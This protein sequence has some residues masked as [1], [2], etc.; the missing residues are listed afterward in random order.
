MQE[1]YGFQAIDASLPVEQIS[2]QL[3]QSVLPLLPHG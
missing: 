1:E 2:E 3:K